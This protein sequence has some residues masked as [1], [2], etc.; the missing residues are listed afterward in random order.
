MVLNGHEFNFFRRED[1][2]TGGPQLRRSGS[3]FEN[4]MKQN[5]NWSNLKDIECILVLKVIIMDTIKYEKN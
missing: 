3:K 5:Q 4:I 1:L 2:I